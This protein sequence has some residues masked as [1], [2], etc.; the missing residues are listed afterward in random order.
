VDKSFQTSD[1]VRLHYQESGSGTVLVFVPGW[2]ASANVWRAQIEYFS[3]KY[4]VVA[5]DPRSQGDSDKPACGN[6]PERRARDI[7]ELIEHLDAGPVVA[8]GWSMG[9]TELL[10]YVEQFATDGVDGFVFVDSFIVKSDAMIRDALSLAH[11]L[12]VDRLRTMRQFIRSLFTRPQSEDFISELVQA[13]MQTPIDTA[14]SLLLTHLAQR[15]WRSVLPKIDKP[16]LLAVQRA[17]EP[18]AAIL[19]AILPLARVEVFD[20]SGHFLFVEEAQRFNA[21]V[22]QFIETLPGVSCAGM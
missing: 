16:V 3:Q 10:T 5:L 12:Q 1:R 20:Q 4:R 6:Y 8:V 17:L 19:R 13:S 22:D 2:I 9:M 14:L 7:R 21:L 11:Q 15:D 18:D